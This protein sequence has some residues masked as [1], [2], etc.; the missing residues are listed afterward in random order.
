M[1]RS[2]PGPVWAALALA[3]GYTLWW[4]SPAL[5]EY[6]RLDGFGDVGRLAIVF[7][8]LSIAERLAARVR[9]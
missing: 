6:A 1:S 7:L 4:V 9:H 2:I 5:L 8:G 3:L